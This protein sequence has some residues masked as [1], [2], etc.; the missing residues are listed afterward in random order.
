MFACSFFL[1]YKLTERLEVVVLFDI[2]FA[3]METKI[4][5]TFEYANILFI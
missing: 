1:N 2:H 3:I 5:K 4:Y